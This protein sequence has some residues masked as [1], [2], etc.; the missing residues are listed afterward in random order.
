MFF[1]GVDSLGR[2]TSLGGFCRSF[3]SMLFGKRFTR[4][5]EI[6]CQAEAGTKYEIPQQANP[7][8]PMRILTTLISRRSLMAFLSAAAVHTKRPNADSRLY[9]PEKSCTS[10]IFRAYFWRHGQLILFAVL[11]HI[12]CGSPKSEGFANPQDGE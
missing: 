6:P 9:A 10:G 4:L 3:G 1:R 12:L 11:H 8:L 7:V 5:Q 2:E